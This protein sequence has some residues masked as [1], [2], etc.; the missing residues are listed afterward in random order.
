MTYQPQDI[1]CETGVLFGCL[2]SITSGS[3]T[4]FDVS[5]GKVCIV[6]WTNVSGNQGKSRS[7]VL[8]YSGDTGITPLCGA[9]NNVITPLFITESISAGIA[10]LQ[11]EEQTGLSFNNETRRDKVLLPLVLHP[12][13]SGDISGF[14]DN[15]QLAFEWEQQLNDLIHIIGVTSTGNRYSSGLSGNFINR[16]AG[17]GA[18]LHFNAFN[19]TKNPVSRTSTA[20]SGVGIIYTKQ[21]SGGGSGEFVP[22]RTTIDPD[23]YDNNGTLTAVPNNNFTIQTIFFFPQSSTETIA[24][25]QSLFSSLANAEASID[26]NTFDDTFIIPPNTLNGVRVTYLIV[27]EGTTDLNVGS[28]AK[29]KAFRNAI[30]KENGS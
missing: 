21:V 25:G 15:I 13:I 29:F 7:Q 18:R 17:S 8:T 28:E 14:T 20:V 2:A 1:N 10:Q 27:Q 12:S 4:Q 9:T 23:Q 22:F 3:T 5:S 19:D 6:D 16:E 24:Y 30:V 11:Q 26:D